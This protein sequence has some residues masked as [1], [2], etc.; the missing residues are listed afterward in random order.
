MRWAVLQGG[1]RAGAAALAPRRK[2][3][4]DTPGVQ[5]LTR[6]TDS[7]EVPVPGLDPK[8]SL[9][10][11]SAVTPTFLWSLPSARALCPDLWGP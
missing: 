3:R 5:K 10:S 2:R 4:L 8:G 1:R 6:V 11:L 9:E 7:S